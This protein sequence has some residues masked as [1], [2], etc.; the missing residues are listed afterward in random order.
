MKGSIC[1]ASDDYFTNEDI[2]IGDK[3]STG[4][5]II[6]AV[7]GSVKKSIKIIKN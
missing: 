7:Y 2:K 3:L 5:Y 1:Y 6:N 4:V